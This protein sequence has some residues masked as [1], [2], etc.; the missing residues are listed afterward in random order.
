MQKSLPQLTIE[1]ENSLLECELGSIPVMQVIDRRTKYVEIRIPNDRV[2]NYRKLLSTE[3]RRL[4]VPQPHAKSVISEIELEEGFRLLETAFIY[5]V[6]E[7]P[8]L[9]LLLDSGLKN[10]EHYAFITTVEPRAHAP[11]SALIV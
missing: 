4:G 6:E 11:Q 7:L 9:L 5:A 3:A 2:T 8:Q 1:I 10:R